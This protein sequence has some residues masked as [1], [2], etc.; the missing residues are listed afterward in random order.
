M[1]AMGSSYLFICAAASFGI[2]LFSIYEKLLQATGKTIYSTAAQ[3]LGAA[4]NIILDPILIFGWFGMPKLGIEGAAYAT[5]IG[6]AL[7]MLAAMYF[8]YRKN[9]E[10]NKSSLIEFGR[11]AQER[12]GR[13]GRKPGTFTFLG[14]IQYCSHGRNS[15]F[16]VKRKTSRKKFAKKRREVSQKI[17]EMRTLP[18]KEI[19]KKLNQILAGHYHYYGITDNYQSMSD[20]RYRT[21]KSLYC[22]QN[23][24]ILLT[25]K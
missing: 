5:V 17:N 9:T 4:C 3:I 8:H 22:S 24:S 19:T 15:K 14:F 7:S 11:Y 13:K 12:C 21:K 18:I 25:R 1:F 16:R 23:N 10:E 20:F 6:Q 2:L